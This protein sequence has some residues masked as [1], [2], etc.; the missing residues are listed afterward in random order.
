[1][2]NNISHKLLNVKTTLCLRHSWDFVFCHSLQ[3]VNMREQCCKH[4]GKT[5]QGGISCETIQSVLIFRSKITN[6]L[7]ED[8]AGT[9]YHV[10][11]PPI[12]DFHSGR[13]TSP[14]NHTAVLSTQTKNIQTSEATHFKFI[15]GIK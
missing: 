2:Q 9:A 13:A 5:T 10:F 1:M 12:I 3:W 7:S 11:H 4:C 8:T 6:K 14:V 15:D